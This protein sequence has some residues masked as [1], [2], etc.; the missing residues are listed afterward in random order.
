[1]KDEKI[2]VAVETDFHMPKMNWYRRWKLKRANKRRLKNLKKYGIDYVIKGDEMRS[3]KKLAFLDR[4]YKKF[5]CGA[6]NHPSGWK[7]QKRINAKATRR[8]LKIMAD[9]G[10]E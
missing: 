2:I 10:E 4:F 8:K 5:C 6:K 9:K 3:T 7:K 1:M